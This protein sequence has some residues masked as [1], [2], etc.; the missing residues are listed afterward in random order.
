M[1]IQVT[2]AVLV[3]VPSRNGATCSHNKVTHSV[4]C[5]IFSPDCMYFV[6]Y[7]MK[8][9][10]GALSR[11]MTT[12]GS[13]L[14]PH[15]TISGVSYACHDQNCQAVM[16]YGGCAL[17]QYYGPMIYGGQVPRSP[18]C[19]CYNVSYHVGLLFNASHREY[20]LSTLQITQIPRCNCN[21]CSC[22]QDVLMAETLVVVYRNG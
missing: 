22:M 1:K 3:N 11:N 10:L 2:C 8:P 16:F 17:I 19:Y 15:R 14:I 6:C 21:A 5:W 4:I 13:H 9:D 18:S 12:L 20:N 7:P